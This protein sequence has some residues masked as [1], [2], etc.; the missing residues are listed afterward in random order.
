MQE[1][2]DILTLF[3]QLNTH[4]VFTS[5]KIAREMLSLLPLHVW[6]NP[7]ARFLDP[8][9]KSGIFLREAMYLFA[10]NLYGMGKHVG[11]DGITYDLNDRQQL[12]NHILKNMLFG[13]ATSELTGYV[14]RRT[15]YGVMKADTDKQT[16]L[17]E[18]FEKSKNG[19]EWSE[20]EKVD[21]ITR[22]QYNDYYDHKMFSTAE[23]AGYSSEGNIFYP[24][25]E[26]NQIAVDSDD[27]TIDEKY[28]PFIE[29][30]TAHKK[31]LEIRGGAMKFDVVVMNPPYQINTGVE[32]KAFAVPVYDK[33]VINAINLN[34]EHLVAI[35]PS[36][37]FAGG[38]GLD[39]FRNQMLNDG[40]IKKI[41]DFSDSIVCFPGVEIKGGV[42]YFH[43]DKNHSGDT[44]VVS[45]RKEQK[46]DPVFRP[47]LEPG[48]DTFI[49]YNEAISII[50]KVSL[51]QGTFSALV[52]P[53]TPFG[54]IS[55]FKDYKELPFSGSV[56]LYVQGGHGYVDKSKISK[57][58]DLIKQHK[59]FIS[60]SYNAGEN[61]PHQ[62]LNK[63][64]Y[65]GTDSCCTQTYLCIGPFTTELESSNVLTY[66]RTK[67]FRFMVMIRKISQ[68]NMRGVFENVPLQDWSESWTDEK[69]YQKYG[70]DEQEISFIESMIRPME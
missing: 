25:S 26:V 40:R 53:Q 35:I 58:A 2:K 55:S 60:K 68:D 61:F 47:L 19:R 51:E 18:A 64:F 67:F 48:M 6:K 69:L 33:F 22:N 49:R 70:L 45:Y 1:S 15:L 3:E 44:E 9:T 4:E 38:R 37:W 11:H 57:G 10:E 30:N 43:W 39:D 23:Y 27:F 20:S 42:C 12:I 8:A 13:I 21:F 17:I 65:G 66:M 41:V 16:A 56:K 31:I 29:N 34:P 28:F 24:T 32:S 14:A 62:I 54:L 7:S 50:R 59:I 52:S 46:F 63:P 5:P 36:R